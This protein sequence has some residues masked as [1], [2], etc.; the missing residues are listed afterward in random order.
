[1]S[2]WDHKSSREVNCVS[3]ACVLVRAKV[4]KELKGFDEDF[5]MY[6]ED[7]DLCYRIKQKGF[8]IFYDAKSK[9]Y[10]YGGASSQAVANKAVIYDRRSIQFFFRKHFGLIYS[11]LYRLEC[12][13]LSLIL[14][15]VLMIVL[16][17]VWGRIRWRM[18]KLFIESALVF[19]WGIRLERLVVK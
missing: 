12:V 16:C 6:G 4:A 15:A 7:V 13:L 1:M 5:F 19:F 11:L 3:G 14:L 9:I 17:F 10:H 8:R 2:Y 18:R